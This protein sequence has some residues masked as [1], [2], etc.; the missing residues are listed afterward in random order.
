MVRALPASTPPSGA[1]RTRTWAF[2]SRLRAPELWAVG[3]GRLLYTPPGPH[4]PLHPVSAGVSAEPSPQ[5]RGLQISV[6]GASFFAPG[7]LPRVSRVPTGRRSL[8]TRAAS[9]SLRG[10]HVSSHPGIGLR[11][12]PV[13][14]RRGAPVWGVVRGSF[15]ES[16]TLPRMLKGSGSHFSFLL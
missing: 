1:S 16:W 6:C 7:S 14:V 8:F 12:L 4:G 5:L 2:S 13:P 9:R 3:L 10:D 11:C 15:E